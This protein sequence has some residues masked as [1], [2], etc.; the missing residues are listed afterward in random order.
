MWLRK[1]VSNDQAGIQ[2]EHKVTRTN[3]IKKNISNEQA[4]IQ[5]ERK[6]TTTNVLKKKV[7]Q[8]AGR[9][10]TGTQ[11]HNDKSD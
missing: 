5:Q 6:T 4:A 2:Q 8:W 7:I 11:G 10:P 9:R 1:N 3:V